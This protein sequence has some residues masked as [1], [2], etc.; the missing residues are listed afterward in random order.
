[1]EAGKGVHTLS[2]QWTFSCACAVELFLC[3]GPGNRPGDCGGRKRSPHPLRT[4]NVVAA[5]ALQSYFLCSGPGNRP[6]DCG[7]W[8]GSPHPLRTVDI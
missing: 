1:V 5:L 3:L 7:G 4:V 2:A 8:K 6:G